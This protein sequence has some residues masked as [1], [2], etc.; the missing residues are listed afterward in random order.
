MHRLIP[1]QTDAAD[2]TPQ[3]VAAVRARLN[4]EFVEQRGYK[5]TQIAAAT[6]S[7]SASVISEF[8]ADKY[9]GSNA[10]V[11]LRLDGWMSDLDDDQAV[12]SEPRFVETQLYKRVRDLARKTRRT[13]R[14]SSIYGEHSSGM[15]KTTAFRR[16]ADNNSSYVI[17]TCTVT[18]ATTVGLVREIARQ[19][20]LP[21]RGNKDDLFRAIVDKLKGSRSRPTD[22]GLTLLIDDAQ[23]LCRR[24]DAEPF[25]LLTQIADASGCPQ[26][27]SATSNLSAYFRERVRDSKTVSRQS[28]VQV[29]RRLYRS[30]DVTRGTRASVAAD[31]IEEIYEGNAKP[32]DA[33]AIAVLATVANYPGAGGLG[34]V[35]NLV[36]EAT[37]YADHPEVNARKLTGKIIQRVMPDDTRRQYEEATGKAAS[38]G[39][40]RPVDRPSTQVHE[41]AA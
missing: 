27:W 41:V 28:L 26:L 13:R 30:V 20:D 21:T 36:R 38:T 8:A 15:G 33:S 3:Q 25:F 17:V 1:E 19:L 32:L 16:L 12:E 22:S 23:H 37:D 39:G 4:S 35:D 40:R 34:T 31:D 6:H 10:K 11:A 9:S 29:S 14:V 2:V 18:N 5:F 24:P 7:K